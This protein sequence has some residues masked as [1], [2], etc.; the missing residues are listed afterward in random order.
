MALWPADMRDSIAVDLGAES[1]R[2][3]L[4]RWVE[5]KPEITLVHRFAN[6]PRAVDGGL[7]WDLAMIEEGVAHRVRAPAAIATQGGSSVSAGRGS[8]GYGARTGGGRA[9]ARPI[10]HPPL[11]PRQW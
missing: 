9:L 4:L 8:G 5:G 2:V 3:S 1:C 10:S 11:T 7:R 6:A